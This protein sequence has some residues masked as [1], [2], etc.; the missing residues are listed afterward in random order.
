MQKWN[1]NLL[2]DLYNKYYKLA[3]QVDDPILSLEYENIANS[4]MNVIERYD[5]LSAKRRLNIGNVVIP[6]HKEIVS[7]DFAILNQ[8]SEYCPYIRLLADYNKTLQIRP[9]TELPFIDVS[10]SKIVS[11]SSEFYGQFKGIFSEKFEEIKKSFNDTLYF[12]G[13]NTNTVTVGQALPIYKSDL[14]FFELG[15]N[16][17]TQDYVS[18]IHEFG[19]GVSRLINP[20]AM[21]DFGKYCF[22]E[23]DSLFFEILGTDFVGN[24]LGNEKDSYDISLQVLKDYIYSAVLLTKKL[25]LYVENDRYDLNKRGFVKRYLSEE[26][27]LDKSDVNDILKM[28]LRENMHYIVSYLTA[29]ELYLI[30]QDDPTEALDILFNIIEHEENSA[31][32]YLEYVRELGI[33]PGKNFDKYVE[34]LFNK[35]KE[36]K[37]E[38]S[39]RY[40]N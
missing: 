36:L 22:I 17:T 18:A 11:V 10:V 9:N 15:F 31:A 5:E 8:Y 6:N 3:N 29:I 1:I 35:A 38:K 14:T 23:V 28:Y 16:K 24:Y 12:K 34:I 39:L 21:W 40:K 26:F 19:H 7:S 27:H 33:E 4:V 32:D 25:D 20:E 37:D 2:R 30:Y 13:I